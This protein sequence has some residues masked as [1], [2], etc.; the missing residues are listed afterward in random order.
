MSP[1]FNNWKRALGKKGHIQVHKRSETHK[2]AEE[3][4]FLQARQPGMNIQARITKQVSEQQ[5]R[6]Y[7]GILSIIDITISLGLRGI[8]LRGNWD[9][10]EKSEDGNFAY[11]VNWKSNFDEDLKEHMEHASGNGKYTSPMI[12]NEIINLCEGLVREKI[13]WCIPEPHG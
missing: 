1:G 2:A 3:N 12:Q 8:P 6:T 13:L 9:K 4:L 11:F 7:K 10:V 5:V